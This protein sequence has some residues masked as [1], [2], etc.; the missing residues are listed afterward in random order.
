MVN[1]N[2]HLLVGT[3]TVYV[4]TGRELEFFFFTTFVLLLT[5]FYMTNNMFSSGYILQYID[6]EVLLCV[7]MILTIGRYLPRYSLFF[8]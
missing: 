3:K 2:F 6:D 1:K 7:L 5:Q 8:L 4:K